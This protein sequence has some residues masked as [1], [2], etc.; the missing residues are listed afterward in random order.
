M[1]QRWTVL[2]VSHDNLGPG[3]ISAHPNHSTVL[4]PCTDP[5]FPRP[6]FSSVGEP[7]LPVHAGSSAAACWLGCSW[8]AWSRGA[9]PER[10][11]Q[12]HL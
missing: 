3:P 1:S 10:M 2:C 12:S 4:E 6:L 5:M 7:D 11:M 8:G 9:V